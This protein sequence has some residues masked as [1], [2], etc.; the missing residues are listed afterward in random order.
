MLRT[1]QDQTKERLYVSVHCV[2]IKL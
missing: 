2:F 1:K